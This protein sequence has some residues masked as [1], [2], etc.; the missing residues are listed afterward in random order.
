MSFWRKRSATQTWFAVA[1]RTRPRVNYS[2]TYVDLTG[3]DE[4]SGE[5]YTF[6]DGFCGA[7]VF[8]EVLYKQ[9]YTFSGASTSVQK[10]WI[11]TAFISRQR[12]R[13]LARSRAF[14]PT[15]PAIS[16]STSYTFPLPI[17]SSAKTVA[18]A[19]DSANEPVSFQLAGSC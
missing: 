3:S 16:W 10:L 2:P 11:H 14:P 9:A 18:A 5:Q 13:R 6:G 17:F 19:T 7:G 4:E 1:G 8:L 15:R 12:L